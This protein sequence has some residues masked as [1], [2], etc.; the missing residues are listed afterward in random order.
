MATLDN[1]EII[2]KEGRIYY[3]FYIKPFD[4][5]TMRP[6]VFRFDTGADTCMIDI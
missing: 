3:T 5:V 4:D 2:D 6:I 1:R